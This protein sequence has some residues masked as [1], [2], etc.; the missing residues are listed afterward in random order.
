MKC[1]NA[2]PTGALEPISDQ[3]DEILAKVRMGTARVDENICNSFNGGV[4][5]ACV[6][7]CPFSGEA[8]K[9]GMWERPIV[10]PDKCVGC[11]L[12]EAS[13][14]VYPQAIRVIPAPKGDDEGARA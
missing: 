13:C 10:D 1:T 12:C 9:A 11:G 3:P 7:A 2:C 5:G 4:C 14:I 8:L 6:R